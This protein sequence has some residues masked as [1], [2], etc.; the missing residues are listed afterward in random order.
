MRLGLVRIEQGGIGVLP[1]AP[2]A[3][4]SAG[5]PPLLPDCSSESLREA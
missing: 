5:M 3:A 2:G 4:A 1:V